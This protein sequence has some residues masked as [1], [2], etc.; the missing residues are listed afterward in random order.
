MPGRL[1]AWTMPTARDPAWSP[2]AARASPCAA[3]RCPSRSRPTSRSPNPPGCPAP[4]SPTSSAAASTP[5]C[6]RKA[7]LAAPRTTAS[8]LASGPAGCSPGPTGAAIGGSPLRCSPASTSSPSSTSCCGTSVRPSPRPAT[9]RWAAGWRWRSSRPSSWP[10]GCR[11]G[12][13]PRRSA[14]TEASS[15]L[16]EETSRQVRRAERLGGRA[17]LRRADKMGARLTGA[18]LGGALFWTA[19]QLRCAVG[20][21]GTTLPHGADRPAHWVG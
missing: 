6:A 16:L 4:T 12:S 1:S 13:A 15:T 14:L 11:S 10:T 3:W 19:T 7:F 21:A 5:G 17:D 2:T 18:D 9:A 8:E 20:D